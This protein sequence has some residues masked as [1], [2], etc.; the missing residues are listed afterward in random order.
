MHKNM[1]KYQVVGGSIFRVVCPNFGHPTR[2]SSYTKYKFLQV[3]NSFATVL[4]QLSNGELL[5]P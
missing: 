2:T 5:F 4:Y 3:K 1:R